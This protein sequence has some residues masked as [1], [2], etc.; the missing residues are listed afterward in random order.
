MGNI[1]N[2]P[3]KVLMVR[4]VCFG[5]NYQTAITN[6]FQHNDDELSADEVQKRAIKEFDMYV[7]LLKLHGIDVIVVQDSP[8]PHTP[9]SISP[10]NV[11]SSHENGLFILYP[12]M[13]EN[14]R[15]ER[16]KDYLSILSNISRRYIDFTISEDTNQFLEGTGSIVFDYENKISYASISPRT[17]KNLFEY[18]SNYLNYKP[19]SFKSFDEKGKEIYH[20]NVVLSIGKGYAVICEECILDKEEL[21]TV[22]DSLLATKHKLITID[23]K[24][25]NSFAGNIYQLFNNNGE[26]F[27]IMSDQAYN[28]YKKEQIKRLEKF[29][30]ILHTPLTTIEKYGGGS[31]RCMI[32]EIRE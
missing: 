26:S 6:S 7:D 12:M 32:A 4:P 3:S 22:E 30:K 24:Q 9:D 21:K 13:A 11:F 2:K 5:F 10:N 8:V 20:T 14:R 18:I 23:N 17:D 31:A 19:I 1:K 15:L 29:G 27:I 25:L 16:D 28:S